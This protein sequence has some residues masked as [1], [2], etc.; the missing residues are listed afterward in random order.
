MS[1]LGAKKTIETQEEE[2]ALYRTMQFGDVV[3][4]LKWLKPERRW[5]LLKRP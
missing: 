2:E 4:L 5:V 1:S 3:D